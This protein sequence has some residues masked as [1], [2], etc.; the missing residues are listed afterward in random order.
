MDAHKEYVKQ[1]LIYINSELTQD[2]NIGGYWTEG[3][4]EFGF[5]KNED[6]VYELII[7]TTNV[8]GSLTFNKKTNT[9]IIFQYD[10]ET[11][12]FYSLDYSQS[13]KNIG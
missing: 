8:N 4:S 10:E 5:E 9:G 7:T 3:T 12:Y 13:I 1:R 11:G 2:G 6:G